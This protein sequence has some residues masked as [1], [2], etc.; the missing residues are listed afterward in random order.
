M[1]VITDGKGSREDTMWCH[2]KFGRSNQCLMVIPPAVLR[3]E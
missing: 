3:N 1:E 2:P